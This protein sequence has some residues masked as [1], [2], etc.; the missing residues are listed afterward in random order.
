MRGLPGMFAPVYQD[1]A[2]AEGDGAASGQGESQ[3]KLSDGGAR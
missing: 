3:T 2:T 1:L